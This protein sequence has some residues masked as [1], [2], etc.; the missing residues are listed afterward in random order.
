MTSVRDL[1]NKKKQQVEDRKVASKNPYKFKS[2]K[3]TIRILPSWR[4][5]DD[6][7]FF[8]DFGQSWIKSMDKKV[9]AVVADNRITFGT[10]DPVRN[11]INMAMA[12]ARTDAQ[13]EHY[14]EMLAKARVL[15]NALILDD[16]EI[17]PETPEIVEFSESQFVKVM[18]AADLAGILDEFLS[19]ENGV[20]L[21]VSKSGKGFDTEYNFAFDRKNSK[22]NPKV[23]ENINDIDAFIRAKFADAE[24]AVN[25]I[26]TLTQSETLSLTGPSTSYSGSADVVDAEY[27]PIEDAKLVD[28]VEA[29]FESRT[30]TQEDLDNLFD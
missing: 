25:A 13:R 9:M 14:K 1:V 21:I 7:T 29:Q 8:H 17:D 26:K 18:E 23:M 2:G 22:V 12:E 30:V 24:K 20:N 4:G 3:T 5:A 15:V 16:K 27:D 10:D 11:L 19:L 6:P 28:S